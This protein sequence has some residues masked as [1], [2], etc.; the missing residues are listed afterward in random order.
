MQETTVSGLKAR[1]RELL[2]AVRGGETVVVHD[3]RTPIAC[4]IPFERTVDGLDVVEP[5]RP[6]ACRR[7]RT[8]IVRRS[9]RTGTAPCLRLR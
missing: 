7:S 1:L 9:A 8:D 6:V 5:V 2:A 4:L 3:R